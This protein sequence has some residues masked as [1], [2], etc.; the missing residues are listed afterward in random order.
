MMET[1]KELIAATK[2]LHDQVVFLTSAIEVATEINAISFAALR[3]ADPEAYN[4]V[5]EGMEPFRSRSTIHDIVIRYSLGIPGSPGTKERPQW[6][7]GV[8]TGK[9]NTGQSAER[10]PESD[11]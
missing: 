3:E 8:L 5:K 2:A 10:G 6:F 4:R 11:E 7:R 9:A 1:I